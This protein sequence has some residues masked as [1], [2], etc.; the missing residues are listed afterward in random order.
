ME[1]PVTSRTIHCSDPVA[2]ANVNAPATDV[3]TIATD[4]CG[5][6]IMRGYCLPS[7]GEPGAPPPLQRTHIARR[8]V[9]KGQA[10]FRQGDR[11][12][13]LYAVRFGSFKSVTGLRDGREQV[14]S[15]HLPGEL[16]GFEGLADGAQ[17]CTVRAI[18]DA[19]VCVLPLADVSEAAGESRFVLHRLTQALSMELV[20]ERR[21]AALIANTRSEERVGTFLLNLSQRLSE[22][23]YSAREFQLR[24]TREEIGS[25][26]GATLE[27]VSRC[28]SSLAR[29]GFVTVHRRQIE[30]V[31]AD[32]LRASYETPA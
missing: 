6:C 30:I 14:M 24:M 10:V 9:R 21:M 16:F 19:E 8:R 28:L 13:Y 26:L 7:W 18:E 17:P 20:R 29:Q 25:Y 3:D 5:T 11:S 4:A 1:W 22:R 23:G 27:T 2:P 15:F 31:D 12:E 32:G